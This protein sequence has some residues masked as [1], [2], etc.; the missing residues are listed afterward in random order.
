MSYTSLDFFSPPPPPLPPSDSWA[1][2]ASAAAHVRPGHLGES[3]PEKE[4]LCR[5]FLKRLK[6]KE[7]IKMQAFINIFCLIST[8]ERRRS[9]S[10][11]SFFLFFWFMSHIK[12]RDAVTANEPPQ[13]K[14]EPSISYC[15]ESHLISRT[16]LAARQL[17]IGGGGGGE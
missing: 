16:S 9:F 14:S 8:A 2:S 15:T 4:N 17:F 7:I 1:V 13:H 10:A 6:K 12:R 11:V 3:Q 5:S